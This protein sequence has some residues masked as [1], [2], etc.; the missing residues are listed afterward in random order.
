MTYAADV[1]QSKRTKVS[2]QFREGSD[3]VMFTSD[4]SARGLDYPDVSTVIQVFGNLRETETETDRERERQRAR[5]RE[6]E[7]R[8]HA[9]TYRRRHND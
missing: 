3:L 7:T 6:R 9:H 1:C 5:E 4:V 2:E 8:T